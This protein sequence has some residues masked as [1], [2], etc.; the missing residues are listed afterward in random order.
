MTSGQVALKRKAA[1]LRALTLVKGE[2]RL[3]IGSGSTMGAFL[4]ELSKGLSSGTRR[5]RVVPSSSQVELECSRLGLELSSLYDNPKLEFV[6]DSADE[7]D[8]RGNLLKGGGAALTREKVVHSSAEVAVIIA[9]EEKMVR[10]LGTRH[11]LPIEVLPFALPYVVG[12]VKRLFSTDP[13][14]RMLMGKAGPLVTDNGNYILDVPLGRMNDPA[15]THSKLKAIS[16]VVETGLFFSRKGFLVIGTGQGAKV[17]E[18]K[19]AQ[20]LSEGDNLG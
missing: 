5:V 4:E 9:E 18:T 17:I 3:G 6:V 20:S 15:D 1:I 10:E 12:E 14:V 2:T 19:G 7:S 8:E 16:G 13:S 11:P